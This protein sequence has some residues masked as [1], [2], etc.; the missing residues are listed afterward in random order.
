MRNFK[1]DLE[2]LIDRLKEKKPFT[3]SKYADGEF[4][5]LVNHKITNCDNWT[6]DPTLHA[7]EQ[8]LLLN[9]FKYSG[10]NYIVGISCPCCVPSSH[11][12]WMRDESGSDKITWA[13][14]F[15]N[16]NYPTVKDEIFPIFDNWDGKVTLV[17]NEQGMNRELPFKVDNYIPI[18][19]GSWFNPDLDIII[20]K[21]KK[22][23]KS[24]SGQ[25]FLFSGGPLGNILAH[26]LHELNP[27]NTYIDIGSTINPWVTRDNRGYLKDN[28]ILKT[29]IW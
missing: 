20:E 15:V 6:F 25:L 26:Q 2:Q 21:M 12:K 7:Y 3:F 1:T 18:T 27:G 28:A 16:S 14:L 11:V 4:A 19:I 8:K 24:A 9:S 17:A 22:L 29:C 10:K 5:I 23:A 13:N